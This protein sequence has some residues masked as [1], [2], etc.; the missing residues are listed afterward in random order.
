MRSL[1]EEVEVTECKSESD[2]ASLQPDPIGEFLR[3]SVE[4]VQR[5]IG[6]IPNAVLSFQIEMN[7]FTRRALPQVC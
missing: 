2:R 5:Y 7:I 6:R 4:S 3:S 1:V